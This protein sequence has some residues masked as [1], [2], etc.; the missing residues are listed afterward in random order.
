MHVKVLDEDVLRR[1]KARDMDALVYAPHFTPLPEIERRAAAYTDE[2]LLVVPAR[3]IFTG[4]WHD[5]KH[6]LAI[7]LDSPVPDFITLE[8]ALLELRSQD[9]ATLVPHP[10]FLT[11]SLDRADVD[12]YRSLLDGAEIYNPKFWPHHGRRAA[13][14]AE[15]AALP[16]FASSYAHLGGSVGEAW[17]AFDPADVEPGPSSTRGPASR[18][19]GGW[20]VDRTW[21]D[22]V[23]AFVEALTAGVPQSTSRRT[24]LVH[25]LRCLAEFAHLGYENSLPKAIRTVQ[26]RLS[27][28]H[29]GRPLYDGRFDD[30]RVY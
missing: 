18:S 7:G 25:R 2:E 28:T 13:A 4:D 8:G 29:P 15:E 6:L 17:T 3:E 27:S 10:D 26:P 19:D 24:G 1:A 22:R 14:I 12:R 11:V 16:A 20:L 30:V 21:S 5:R 9:A 23:E